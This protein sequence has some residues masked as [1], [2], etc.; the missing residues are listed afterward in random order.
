MHEWI[1]QRCIRKYKEY[2]AKML[3]LD[4]ERA[5]VEAERARRTAVFLGALKTQQEVVSGREV[6][7]KHRRKL[8]Q[9]K[10]KHW[11]HGRKL[12][13]SKRKH[14]QH[15]GSCGKAGSTGNTGGSC[16]NPRGSF[17]NP[18]GGCIGTERVKYSNREEALTARA[19]GLQ[20]KEDALTTQAR[21]LQ[22]RE[23]ALTAAGG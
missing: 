20:E 19:R 16:S 17:E 6:I 3:A 18:T 13:Q 10:R 9:S 12:W 2:Q 4:E 15:G 22:A 8:W 7:Y 1:I 21:D 23:E 5:A 14:W 11:Q